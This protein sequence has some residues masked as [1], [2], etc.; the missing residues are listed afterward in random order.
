MVTT[1]GKS[2]VKRFF[3]AAP[4]QIKERVLRGAARS[5]AN[6]VADEAR[7]RVTSD[8][9]A[10]AIKVRTRIEGDKIIARVQV[11]MGGYNLPIWLEYGT[12][13]HFISVDD[14][15][16]AGLSVRKVNSKTRD[17]SLVIGGNFVGE[18][19]HHPG[20]RAHPFLRPSLDMKESE[21]KAAAQ[22]FILSR[23][24]RTG[25]IGNDEG[26]EA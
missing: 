22:H 9:V 10:R 25:I 15:Q 26:D 14:S 12:D 1:R 21:A 5:A 16:R 6:V 11:L 23:V 17:G 20:A 13:P 8:R 24:K 18:T 7:L 3:A 2:D 4:A 19:V